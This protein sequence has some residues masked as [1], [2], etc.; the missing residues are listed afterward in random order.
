METAFFTK[1]LLL[2]QRYKKILATKLQPYHT[3]LNNSL[4]QGL[5]LPFP[6]FEAIQ[7]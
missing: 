3:L 6:C 5:Y 4:L 1:I 2:S 7:I